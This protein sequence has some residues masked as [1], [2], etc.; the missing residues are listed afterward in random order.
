M[1]GFNTFSSLLNMEVKVTLDVQQF[2]KYSLKGK[3][4]FVSE[5]V[6]WLTNR[7]ETTTRIIPVDKILFV[8]FDG[9]FDTEVVDYKKD[10]K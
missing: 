9:T 5:H 4:V 6:I 10:G 1:K 7:E 3:V 8:E 2:L